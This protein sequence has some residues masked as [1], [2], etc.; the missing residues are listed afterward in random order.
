MTKLEKV[1]ALLAALALILGIGCGVLFDMGLTAT[2]TACG[3]LAFICFI[4]I[5]MA[6]DFVDGAS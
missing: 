1:Q 6:V 4:S 2:A 3:S 5:G